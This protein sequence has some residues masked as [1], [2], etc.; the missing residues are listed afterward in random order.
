MLEYEKSMED[1]VLRALITGN[2]LY[3]L[4][5]SLMI[6][7]TYIRFLLLG[8]KKNLLDCSLRN[9]MSLIMQIC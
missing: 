1:K 8:P 6:V 4:F 3:K 5:I 7:A 9:D 2:L